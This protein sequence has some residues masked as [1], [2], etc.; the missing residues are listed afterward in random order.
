MASSEHSLVAEN[1]VVGYDDGTVI[2]GLDVTLPQGKVTAIIGPNGCGKSTLLRA[3]ARILKPTAGTVLLDG[4]DIHALPTRYVARAV[5]LLPQGTTVPPGI[6]VEDLVARGRFAHQ[7]WLRQWSKV[8][9]D[10]CARAHQLTDTDALRARAVE[11][12]SGGQR[13][14]V[15]IAVAIAQNAPIML[16]D[17]PTTYLDINHRLDLMDLLTRLNREEGRTIVM[18]LHELGDAARYADHLI[19]MK[20]GR[21]VNAGSPHSV[22]TAPAMA[23]LFDLQCDVIPDPLTGAPMVIPHPRSYRE[24][25]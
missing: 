10:I 11:T 1:L 23:E 21:I 6:S 7:T 5:G 12:L 8:D 25:A 13:Q 4:R 24:S 20:E 3:L 19:A 18:V 2:S 16:L 9:S 14:R 22:I 15:W 17:E